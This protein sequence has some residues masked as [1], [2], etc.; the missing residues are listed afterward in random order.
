MRSRATAMLLCTSL[1]LTACGPDIPLA[2]NVRSVA[3]TVPRLVTPAIEYVEPPAT[4]PPVSLPPP[5]PVHVVPP[6]PP[7]PPA[8]PTP[9][10][11]ATPTPEPPPP[12]VCPDA[13]PFDV[14]KLPVSPIV[15]TIPVEATYEQ[16]SEL[17]YSN[18][19][20]E[21]A[22]GPVEAVVTALETTTSSVGQQ[23]DGWSVQRTDPASGASS[24]EVYRLVHPHDSPLATDPGIYLTGMA[25][26]DDVRGELV[27]EAA[28]PGLWLL[29]S[30]VIFAA[31]DGV[32][33]VGS[34][35]DPDTMT[36]LAIVRN[37]TGRKRVDACGDLIDTYTVAMTGTLTSQDAQYQ[38]DWTLQ[39][40]TSYGGLDVE[41]TLALTAP[42]Q[43]FSWIRTTRNT[44]L[45]EVPA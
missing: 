5:P 43:G 41:Q 23:L 31:E 28:G 17:T 14:P 29:P 36:T 37:V 3:I 34:A 35:T 27:F 38:V 4:P 44:A 18:A 2:L 6:P 39:L 30:P 32:Q 9:T 15:H 42:A 26:R 8:P 20:E 40:A 1:L 45:P 25:W 16:Q 13:G 7:A 24:V 12:P 19:A 10:T 11:P 21:V 33:Y 22:A